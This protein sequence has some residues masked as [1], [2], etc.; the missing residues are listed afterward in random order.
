[1]LTDQ[2]RGANK[3]VRLLCVR[4]YVSFIT[5][6]FLSYYLCFLSVVVFFYLYAVLCATS[7]W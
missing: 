5:S 4:L 1:M 3:A 2:F 7:Q 6:L